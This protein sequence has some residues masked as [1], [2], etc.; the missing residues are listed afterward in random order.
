M[1]SGERW[2]SS[3]EA[4]AAAYLLRM[5]GRF[6]SGSDSVERLVD[7]TPARADLPVVVSGELDYLP[8]VYC[9]SPGLGDAFGSGSR[10]RNNQLLVAEKNRRLYL[11]NRCDKP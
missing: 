6:V 7:L 2:R 10:L 9:A 8:L 4:L 3:R 1:Q 11:A 5:F